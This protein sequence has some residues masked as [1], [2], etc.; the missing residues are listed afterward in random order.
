[1][2]R[3]LRTIGPVVAIGRP[4][5]RLAP[6][7]AARIY[8]GGADWR[9]VAADLL[10]VARLVVIRAG[11]MT[12]GIEWEMERV[13]SELPSEKVV[14]WFPQ[15]IAEAAYEEFR[16][17]ARH[18]LKVE[19][20]T[21]CPADFV[22]FNASWTPRPATKTLVPPAVSS[23]CTR[24]KL[25]D[26]LESLQ[27]TMRLPPRFRLRWFVWPV[28]GFWALIESFFL[29]DWY[30]K[31]APEGVSGLVVSAGSGL[32]DPDWGFRFASYGVF[33]LI[34]AIAVALQMYVTNPDDQ[35]IPSLALYRILLIVCLLS[36]VAYCGHL[37]PVQSDGYYRVPDPGGIQHR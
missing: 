3:Q 16:S 35:S 6:L 12:K 32:S 15:A 21:V 37:L 31:L 33:G 28:L 26:L 24:E 20:P 30:I 1:M 11:G 8:V 19:L 10:D 23:A 7:G 5:E 14:L 13:R 29:R 22:T 18:A 17:A 27:R 2:V 9:T 34:F 4:G 25:I 36:I